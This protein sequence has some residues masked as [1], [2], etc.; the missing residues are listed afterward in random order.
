[1][2]ADINRFEQ[3]AR[4]SMSGFQEPEVQVAPRERPAFAMR[5]GTVFIVACSIAALIIFIV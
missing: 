5:F 3:A 2:V 4:L 1:M